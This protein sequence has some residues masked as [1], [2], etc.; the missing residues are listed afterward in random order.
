MTFRYYFSIL[1]FVLLSACTSQKQ[2]TVASDTKS[3]EQLKAH[4]QYLSDDK[5]EG[6]RAG[7]PGEKL[8]MEYIAAQFNVIGLIPKGTDAYYQ[9]FSIN[10][11]KQ[12]SPAT[13]L[14]INNNKLEAG[15]E[16]FPFPYSSNQKIEAQPAIA[17]QEA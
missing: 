8:A 14:T 1:F 15:T 6:R 3:I 2:A 10:D 5:L 7:T 13:W 4:I 9:A 11:G 17:V 16:Y 12:I